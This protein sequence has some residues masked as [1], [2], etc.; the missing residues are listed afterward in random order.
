[1]TAI[2]FNDQVVQ[3]DA[4]TLAD[5]AQELALPAQPM[6]AVLNQQVI[7]RDLWSV[8]QL[9]EHCRLSFFQLVAGG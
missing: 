9:T 5:F 1:M 2:F 7:G 3:T 8:T 4:H 6:A